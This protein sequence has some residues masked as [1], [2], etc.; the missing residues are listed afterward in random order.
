[1]SQQYDQSAFI[2]EVVDLQGFAET[3]M[4]KRYVADILEHGS[5]RS[6]EKATGTNRRTYQRVLARLRTTAKQRGYHH[7]GIGGLEDKTRAAPAGQYN[8]GTST[9][10]PPTEEFPYGQWVLHRTDKK[11]LGL[12]D[13]KMSL[14]DVFENYKG[15]STII[16][17]PKVKKKDLRVVIPMGDPHIGM[18]AWANEAGEDF[19]CDIA[20]RELRSAVKDLVNSSPQA[21]TCILLNL[22][23]FFHA[24]NMAG[25]TSRSGNRLDTDSRWGRVL[26]IGI[27]AMVDCIYACLHK[28]NKVI[29]RNNVGNHD[30]HTSM[31]LNVALQ[32]Y[33]H[34]EK[35]VQIDHNNNR[36]WYHQ[37]GTVLLASTHGDGP[38]PKDLPAIMLADAEHLAGTKHRYWLTGHIH[39]SHKQEFAG[40]MWESFRT[41]AAKDAWHASSGYRSGRDM[42]SIVYHRDFGEVE[43]HIIN[44]DKLRTNNKKRK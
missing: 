21:D 26:Y 39:S 13:I 27:W 25:E 41:L 18:Y 19:D 42:Q 33:F 20:E 17:P 35:R 11:S 34:N 8:A 29:V 3:D 44:I 36:F 5:V 30:D 10:Y 43:R 28:Y 24:D 12:D 1:M 23:D 4:Q 14:I 37:F 9:Y 38:K 31:M 32:M 22:G 15:L 16:K 40:C 7:D 2:K 6:A